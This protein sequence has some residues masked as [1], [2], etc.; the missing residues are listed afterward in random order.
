MRGNKNSA[1]G[2]KENGP[3]RDE[4]FDVPR[5]RGKRRTRED[6]EDRVPGKRDGTGG[7]G[8]IGDRAR[9]DR[10]AGN[11]ADRADRMPRS[12][13]EPRAEALAREIKR[14]RDE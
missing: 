5:E 12:R 3:A 2:F 10:V 8:A 6:A 7:D 11:H 13:D 1:R 14:A 9:R 4:P